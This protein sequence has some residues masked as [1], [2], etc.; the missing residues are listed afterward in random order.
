MKFTKQ[1]VASLT[2]PPGKSDHIVF[3][4]ETA[5]FGVRLRKT[6]SRIFIAQ[7]RIGGRTRRISIGDVGRIELETARVFAK[8]FFAQSVLGTDPIAARAEA[9]ARAAVTVGSTIELYLAARESSL[10]PISFKQITRCLRRYFAGLHPLPVSSVTR[11]DVAAAVTEIARDHGKVA[12]A[13]ARSYLSAF[14]SWTLR[15]GIGGESN[16]VANTNDPAPDEQPRDRVLAPGEIKAVWRSLPDTDFG[17]VV[18]LLFLTGCRRAEIGSL[19]WSEIDLG[20]ALLII[21][22]NR[23]KGGREHRLPLVPE[24]V[25]ILR[26]VTPRPG[27]KFVFGGA[28]NGFTAFQ[29]SMKEL[30]GALAATG[31]VTERFTL[32]DI[33]RSVKSEM[34]DLLIEP[35]ISERILAHVRGGIEGVYDWSRLEGPMRTALRLWADRLRTIV[36][37]AE[38]TVVPMRMPA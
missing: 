10:R 25:E 12:A 14:F 23:M 26:S 38:S 28:R 16:P 19:S 20:R 8:Q 37:G 4:A 9:K 24:A 13:R 21:P 15:E 3:D 5:G 18:R 30:R 17:R 36:E 27:N 34:S 2:L 22:A 6:G 32:H 33:R 29:Y 31:Y 35:W 11:R 1:A 7:M